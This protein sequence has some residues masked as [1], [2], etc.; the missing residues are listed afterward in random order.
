MSWQECRRNRRQIVPLVLLFGV[1]GFHAMYVRC[2]IL[3]DVRCLCN[4]T[5]FG[6]RPGKG[7]VGGPWRSHAMPFGLKGSVVELTS[8]LLFHEIQANTMF[9]SAKIFVCHQTLHFTTFTNFMSSGGQVAENRA[10]VAESRGPSCG[11]Q[12]QSGGKQGPSG[13]KQRPC[14]GTLLWFSLESQVF[15]NKMF[16]NAFVWDRMGWVKHIIYS[17]NSQNSAGLAGIVAGW[18]CV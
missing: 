11:K 5:I 15:V 14:G 13:G 7:A 3:I 17:G 9:L 1:L 6:H 12:R 4:I 10:R 16:L 2:P 8:F 18:W